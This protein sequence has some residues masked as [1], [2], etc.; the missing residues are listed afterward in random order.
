M[1]GSGERRF[2]AIDLKSFYASCECVDRGLDPLTA[3]LV[4]ADR[5]RTSKTI[6][7]AV[8]PGLKSFG[9][10]GRPRL[11]EVEQRVKAVNAE[12]LRHAPSHRFTG[13]FTDIGQRDDP[14]LALDFLVAPPR[15]ARYMEIS[16]KIYSIYLRHVAPEDIFAYSIDEVF[17]DLTGYLNTGGMTAHEMVMGM[18]R[19]VLGETGITATAGIGT[20][21]F[22]AKVA[23]DVVAKHVDADADGVRIA[24]LDERSYREKLWAHRPI[25]DIW[26][27]GRRTA[28]KLADHGFCTMGDIARA[29]LSHDPVR[30]EP[31][32]YRLFGVN[33]ELLIDHAWGYEPATIASI[34]AYR[35]ESS[36]L[37]SGQVLKRPYAFAEA[38]LV[39]MEMTDLLV[40]D[41][42]DKGLVC[43]AVVLTIHYD[44]EN[45]TDPERRA[46]YRG[47]ITR[48]FYGREVPKYAHGTENLDGFSSSTQKIMAAMSRL[49]DRVVDP[50]LLVRRIAV[51]AS[52]TVREED[53]PGRRE[54]NYEQ[55]DLFTD[56]AAVERQRDAERAAMEKERNLQHALLDIKKKYGK[57]AVLRG[58][59]LQEGATAV[60]R[61]GQVGGHRA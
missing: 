48:D 31:V 21:L 6:C 14:S 32:L 43:D 55:L 27:V 30:G 1:G 24:E 23:M 47:E 49:F 56:Y 46:R 51:T 25:T 16:T 41:L 28:A 7:L 59:N 13:T 34:K 8:S 54:E 35:P 45:L 4:V 53:A 26:R 3:N 33:A 19:E 50:D 15:M 9:V 22:L 61:N 2:A 17:I 18:V 52:H 20:N 29:S 37:G 57:N 38:K 10:P 42:V 40:L 36:S 44:V 39:T 5:S 60:E 11:F 58:M 12:R